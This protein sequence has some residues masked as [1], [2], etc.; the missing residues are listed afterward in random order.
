MSHRRPAPPPFA[1]VRAALLALVPL[2]SGASA[3][4]E[5]RVQVPSIES[6]TRIGLDGELEGY[7]VET[8][9]EALRRIG[10]TPRFVDL[11]GARSWEAIATGEL[12]V[13]F[14][15]RPR[16]EREPQ[17]W[18]LGPL[19][20]VQ[21]ALYV[22]RE[23]MPAR[24][25]RTLDD[26]RET[27]LRVGIERLSSYGPEYD[28]LLDDPAFVER[29]RIV[30]G[31]E[32]GIAMLARGRLDAVFADGASARRIGDIDVVRAVELTPVPVHIAVSKTSVGPVRQK[33]LR[34]ALDRMATDGTLDRLRADAEIE[35][36]PP[37]P[38]VPPEPAGDDAEAAATPRPD[39]DPS[40]D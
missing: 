37:E 1:R 10:C 30:V 23:A 13:L 40:T 25:L 26:L 17:A 33:A 3:A 24:P 19:D 28:A 35:N 14:G 39:V 27:R 31:R 8:M 11:P 12:D 36:R 7:A 21:L 6:F 34:D 9:R 15:V 29:L 20:H 18:F 16:P 4:C 5:L 2:L 38:P 22:R 32:A